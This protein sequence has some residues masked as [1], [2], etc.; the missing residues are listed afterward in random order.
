MKLMLGLNETIDQF[1]MTSSVCLYG[2]VSRRED[3]HVF[4]RA[5]QFEVEGQRKK[6]RLKRCEKES[7]KVT[8]CME[9]T[10]C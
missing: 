4:R 3:G 7:M 6:W 2:H 8:L 5:S 1:S 10:L 9:D